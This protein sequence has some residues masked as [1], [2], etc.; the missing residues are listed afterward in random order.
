MEAHKPQISNLQKK[1]SLENRPQLDLIFNADCEDYA[2]LSSG[3]RM[4]MKINPFRISL[5]N[6]LTG[7]KRVFDI[8]IQTSHYQCDTIKVA[9]PEGYS[10]EN[11]PKPT[12]VDTK[13]GYIKTQII[14]NENIITYIQT[15]ELKTGRFSA[16]E[17]DEM[18]KA[19]TRLETLQGGQIVFKKI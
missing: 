16:A 9:I 19:Y 1:E 2:T 6:L 11:A 5:R 7:S 17:F 15:L 18:K 8:D 12:E 4:L 14:E 3:A 13:Y 10:L